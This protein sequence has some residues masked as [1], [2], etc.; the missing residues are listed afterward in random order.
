[1][2]ETLSTIKSSFNG[3]LEVIADGEATV[4]VSV[5]RDKSAA[6]ATPVTGA[7]T[8]PNFL[9]SLN[10]EQIAGFKSYISDYAS[11]INA[12]VTV[13]GIVI[14]APVAYET[15]KATS[16]FLASIFDGISG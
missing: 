12:P 3:T 14:T 9:G 5:S 8:A 16:P 7:P 1:M 13:E 6:V 2:T 4:L 11:E 10:D 15:L